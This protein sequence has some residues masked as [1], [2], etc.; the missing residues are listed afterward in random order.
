MNEIQ[1]GVEF[2]FTYAPGITEEQILGVELAGEMWSNYLG[3]THQYI[4]KYDV[5]HQENTTINIHVEI[6]SDLLPDNVIGGAFPNI[7][8]EYKY[9]DI[10][11]AINEDIT[12]DNDVIAADSLLDNSKANILVNGEII[13]NEK[14]QLTTANLKALDIIDSNSEEGQEL[15]GYILMS[16]LSNF[17]SVEWNYDYLGGAKEGTLDFLTTITHEI[18]HTLGFISGADRITSANE[19]LDYYMDSASVNIINEAVIV[20]NYGGYFAQIDDDFEDANDDDDS[21]FF[22]V[23]NSGTVQFNGQ[24]FSELEEFDGEHKAEEKKKFDKAIEILQNADINTD[25]ELVKDSFNIV[26]SF[27]KKDD[28]WEDFLKDDSYLKNVIES[29]NSDRIDS[30]KLAEKMTSLDLFRYSSESFSSGANELTRG[31]ATYFSLDGSQTGLAMSN[32]LDY[33]GSHWQDR[34]QAEGLGIM[35]PTVALNERWEISN[36]DLMALD[37]IGWDVDYSQT[38]DMQALYNRA[39]ANV[40]SVWIGNRTDEVE[41]ILNGEA[42]DARRSRTTRSLYS[43]TTE[44]YFS[45]FSEVALTVANSSDSQIVAYVDNWTVVINSNELISTYVRAEENE[46]V[47]IFVGN[48]PN[49][50]EETIIDYLEI[51]RSDSESVLLDEITGSLNTGLEIAIATQTL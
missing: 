24:S 1:I 44:G 28:D 32:G 20:R 10:Y 14:F 7:S 21:G 39:S 42:Y 48:T 29:L 31:A 18:G 50:V 38:L 51:D 3:D 12:T 15:D 22:Q 37:A 11:N 6:G 17:S 40:D 19:I 25:P 16:D 33:Q 34:E 8:D 45:T 35:N 36:N 9:E 4:D 5:L 49:F 23:S 13:E 30:E 27:L 2:N 46:T 41:E 26:K 43:M 47:E